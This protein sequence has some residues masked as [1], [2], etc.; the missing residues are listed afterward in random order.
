MSKASFARMNP[1]GQF[2]LGFIIGQCDS[3]L[4]LVD[5]HASDEK[6]NFERLQRTAQPKQQPLV[7]PQQLSLPAGSE[8]I[9]M[10]NIGVFEQSGFK[11][12]INMDAEPTQRIHL[13]A[14]PASKS[15]NFGVS[16][17]EEMV[18]MLTEASPGQVVRPTRL[19]AMFASRACRSSIMIGRALNRQEMCRLLTHMSEMDQPWNCPHGRPTMRHL[20]DLTRTHDDFSKT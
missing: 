3:D 9:V 4:F 13:L 7:L 20:F 5:Q 18:Y 12:D 6:Y 14:A 1:V 2:N 19:R 8:Q 16:D 17:I 10:D 15:W 11:L